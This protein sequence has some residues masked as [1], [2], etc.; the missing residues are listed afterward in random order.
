MQTQ[1]KKIGRMV[2]QYDSYDVA[3]ISRS[4]FDCPNSLITG[5]N[6]G[7]LIPIWYAEAYPSDTLTI[8]TSA[9]ARLLTQI[10]P[11]MD[12][13]YMD[14]HFWCVPNRLVWEHWVNMH[15]ERKAPGDSIDFLTPQ[16]TTNSVTSEVTIGSIFDYF[17]IP[18]NVPNLSFNSLIF[19][20][21][22]LVYNEWYRDENLQEPVTVETGDTDL[23]SNYTLLKR[24]KR[25]DYFTSCLPAPQKGDAVDLPLGTTAPVF[26][27]GKTLGL[28]NGTNQVGLRSCDGNYGALV[29]VTAAYNVSPSGTRTGDTEPRGT[30]GVVPKGYE[31]GMYADLT[32]ATSATINSLR[33]AF[34]I[35]QLLEKDSRGGTR[36]TEMNLAHFGAKSADARLQRPE[37]L[38]GGTFKLNLSVVPQTSATGTTGTPQGNLS[39]FGVINGF[40]KKIVK[41]FTEHCLLFAVASVRADLT[42]QQGLSRFYSRRSRYDYYYPELCNLGEQAVLNKEIFAQGASVINPETSQPYDNEI[43]GYQERWSELR[44]KMNRISGT[45]RSQAPSP[46]DQWHL[47][48]E[49]ENLPVLSPEFIEENPPIDRVIAVEG[50][51]DTPQFICNFFFDETWVRPMSVN[52]I[53]SLRA[54]F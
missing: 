43:F 34:A 28:T 19:R 27:N 13:V 26:G 49:F 30:Y 32:E 3:N 35:Q 38:G 18:P 4:K 9:F 6:S 25:K 1:A 16:L 53:P 54:H 47:A 11:F 17:D 2:H 21:Y 48:Q 51:E 33:Q 29:G 20:A 45:M 7:L 5:L 42:Y 44:T 22:N 40:T 36:Y 10:A 52:S 37:F 41:S 46:L 23:I 14:V 24:G 8:T 15:G 31:S 50:G 12:N 39:S